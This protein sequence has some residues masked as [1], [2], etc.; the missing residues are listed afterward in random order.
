MIAPPAGTSS[1]TSYEIGPLCAAIQL[2]IPETKFFTDSNALFSPFRNPLMI[3][4]PA[5]SSIPPRLPRAP[6]DATRRPRIHSTS[7]VALPIAD[8]A[9]DA[10]QPP[11]IAGSC[12][13]HC[14]APMIQSTAAEIPTFTASQ[15][16]MTMLRKVSLLFHA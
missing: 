16:P 13:N 9:I 5:P 1:F 15:A 12:P 4:I 10:N 8:C 6:E 2:P 3:D 14:T 7:S 11:T